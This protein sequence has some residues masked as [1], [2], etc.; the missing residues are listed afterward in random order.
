LPVSS[1]T[2]YHEEAATLA[3]PT[4]STPVVQFFASGVS[5]VL[6]VMSVTASTSGCDRCRYP[7]RRYITKK[8]DAREAHEEHTFG[9]VLCERRRD[10][11][12]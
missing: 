3:R 1:S 9:A 8:R 10:I 7:R 12:T 4:K 5:V 11:I 2:L 6:F